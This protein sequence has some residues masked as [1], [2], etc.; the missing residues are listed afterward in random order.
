VLVFV[1]VEFVVEVIVICGVR[2]G[3]G[4]VLVMGEGVVVVW[5]FGRG[6]M[7][8]RIWC[9]RGILRNI[10]IYWGEVGCVIIQLRV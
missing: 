3:L 5:G 1:L 2:G 10:W 4:G 6:G 9:F 8:C 7:H